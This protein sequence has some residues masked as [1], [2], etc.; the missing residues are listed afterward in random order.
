MN[1][2][3]AETRQESQLKDVLLQAGVWG[4]F[5]IGFLAL[6]AGVPLLVLGI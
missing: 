5:V 3:Q 1:T 2:M 6:C 4:M